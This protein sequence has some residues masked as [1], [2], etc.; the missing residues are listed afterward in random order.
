MAMMKAMV[1]ALGVAAVLAAVV[2]LSLTLSP[3]AR[4]GGGKSRR[5]AQVRRRRPTSGRWTALSPARRW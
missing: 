1:L 4:G 2:G 3:N 5:R